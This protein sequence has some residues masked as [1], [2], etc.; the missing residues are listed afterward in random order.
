MAK[1]I[2]VVTYE[3]Q[4]EEIQGFIQKLSTKK[5][6]SINIAKKEEPTTLSALLRNEN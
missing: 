3:L 1:Y 2:A 6:T 4:A 5:M